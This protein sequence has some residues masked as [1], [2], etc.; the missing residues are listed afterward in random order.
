M[1]KTGIVVL[2]AL[3][4]LALAPVAAMAQQPQ[5]PTLQVCNKTAASGDAGVKIV[6]RSDALHTGT[7]R[8]RL[9]VGC[10]P[11]SG[12]PTGSLTLYNISMSDSI[13]QGTLI[14]STFEQV[15]TT[16]KHTPTL[17]VNGRCRAEGIEGCRY[18]LMVAN[19]Q[20]DGAQ[21]TPDIVSFL[22]FDGTGQ[23]VAYGTG[24]VVDGDLFVAA[25]SN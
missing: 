2:S 23:R 19:N 9:T 8:V 5:I 18:W 10:D 24:P 22:V 25:T 7:F 11:T 3:S 21:A 15:T 17:Y 16:G 14:A 6:R 1:T 4:V 13:V 12:Y 20:D